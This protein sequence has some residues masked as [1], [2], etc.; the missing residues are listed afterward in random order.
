MPAREGHGGWD[1]QG[2]YGGGVMMGHQAPGMG[3]GPGTGMGGGMGGMQVSAGALVCLFKN[4][5]P[6]G[7]AVLRPQVPNWRRALPTAQLLACLLLAWW[8]GALWPS[9]QSVL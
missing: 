7:S 8:A 2:G 1:Q 3:S 6:A 9:Q 5:A 4:A